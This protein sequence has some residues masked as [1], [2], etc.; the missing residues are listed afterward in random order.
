[1]EVLHTRDVIDIKKE[2]T[3]MSNY[4]IYM[5]YITESWDVAAIKHSFQNE[6]HRVASDL[7]NS[8][9]ISIQNEYILS[10]YHAHRYLF[11]GTLSI[12]NAQSSGKYCSRH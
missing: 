8:M 11:V 2:P 1:M 3:I 9:S 7:S 10:S 4:N 5:F 6:T 12:I